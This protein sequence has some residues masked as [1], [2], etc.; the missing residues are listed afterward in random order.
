VKLTI[1][2]KIMLGFGLIIVAMVF[3][4]AG[5]LY[6]LHM[7]SESVRM[8]LTANLFSIDLAKD[9]SGLLDNEEQHAQKFL[10][11]RDTTYTALFLE[12]ARRFGKRMDSLA[13]V[14]AD[15][16]ELALLQDMSGTHDRLKASVLAS[17]N[18]RELPASATEESVA[19]SADSLR[20]QLETLIRT[21]QTAV[22]SAMADLQETVPRTFNV[23]VLLTLGTIVVTILLALFIA[24]TIT[25]P[26]RAL[27]AGTERVAQG[28]FE[29]IRVT[30]HDE[31]ALLAG[32]FNAMSEKLRQINEYKAEMMHHITHE[33]RMPLQSMH[34]AYYLLSEQMAGPINEQQKKLLES[35][36][37]NIDRI[38]GFSNQFL[39]VAKIEA[40]MMEF[41]R[42]PLGLAE[43][44][45]PV[46]ENARIMAARKEISITLQEE[47][48]PVVTGDGEKLAQVV[49]NLLSNAIK[50]TDRGG[51]ITVALRAAGTGVEIAVSDNGVG[52]DQEDIPRL[53]TKFYQAKNVEKG[54]I[55]GTG[56]GLALVKGIVDGHGGTILVTSQVGRGSTFTVV[57]PAAKDQ[58]Q[59]SDKESS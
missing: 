29:P 49:S 38:N 13:G 36:R 2:R 33:L 58:P 35:M 26:I 34:S 52:I 6:E 46:V 10:V 4:I 17:V 3:A 48:V 27:R 15:S 8:T 22:S 57:L 9:L 18:H 23:A 32:A 31:T 56:V 50:Y 28:H 21:N 59:V 19:N 37:E 12:S 20:T 24:R 5:M 55:K 25:R 30:S 43:L 40:G 51:S 16:S 1:Y 7:V 39:D 53:F 47:E 11:S 14:T 54:S 44:V 42:E 41:R 45:R